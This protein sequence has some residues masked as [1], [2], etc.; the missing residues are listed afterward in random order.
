MLSL[1]PVHAQSPDRGDLGPAPVSWHGKEAVARPV[2]ARLKTAGDF[3]F[4]LVLLIVISPLLLLATLLV[5]LTSRGPVLYCQTRV[6]HKGAPFTIYKLRTMRHRCEE[7]TG[8][9][10]SQPGDTRITPVGRWLRRTHLDELPQLWNVLRCEMSL[11]GPRPERPEFVPQLEK[12]IPFY[13]RRLEVRPG[14]TGLAQVQQPPDTDLQS[15][16]VKLAYDLHYV[17]HMSFWLDF[18]VLTATALHPAGVPFTW[19]RGL[20]GLPRK[21]VV[22][23]DYHRLSRAPKL[24]VLNGTNGQANGHAAPTPR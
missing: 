7:E 11:V 2:Y 3:V 21:Y 8:A 24:P 16:R 4:A 6:G 1:T 20:L 19:I 13:E 22:E 5:K 9:C 12:A 23:Q 17:S 10:W 15:V 18:R 14:L